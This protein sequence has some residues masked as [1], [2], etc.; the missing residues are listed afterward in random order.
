[1]NNDPSEKLKLPENLVITFDLI[2]LEER[3]PGSY[4]AR[5]TGIEASKGSILGFTDADCLPDSNWLK[6]AWEIFSKDFKKE[7]GILTGPVPLFFKDP[8]KLSDAE[9][10]EK[11][12]GFTTKVYAKDGHAITANWFSYKSVLEEFG[13]FNEALKSNGDSELSG[14]VSTKYAIVFNENLIVS[15]PARYRTE[16]LV[17]KYRRLLGGAYSRKFQGKKKYFMIYVFNFFL[18]RYRFA[19]KKLFFVSPKESLAILRVCHEVNKGVL[20]EYFSL[21][22]GGET[23]R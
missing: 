6:Y 13:C 2:V 12:T 7:I 20:N 5:N 23:K 15:H 11:Y 9:I 3:T 8:N 19:L 10:Y 22:Q 1:M 21:I 4:A 14:R 16:D 17:N 18:R